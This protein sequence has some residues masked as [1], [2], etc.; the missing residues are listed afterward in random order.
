VLP[1]RAAGADFLPVNFEAHCRACHP[2]R[3]PAGVRAPDVVAGFDVAHR[4]RPAQLKAELQVGY[5]RGLL[6]AD[7]PTLAAPARPG[8]AFD[9]RHAVAGRTLRAATDRLVRDAEAV[10]LSASTGCAKCHDV[11]K[12]EV[13]PL[14]DHP[15]WLTMAR[16]NHARHKPLDCKACHPGTGAAFVEPGKALVEKEPLQILGIDSCRAC[17]SP[18][19][20]RVKLPDGAVLAGG[21]ARHG[22]VD[23]HK[24]HNAARGLQGRGAKALWPHRPLDIAEFLRGGG[25]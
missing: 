17:H 24:Y 14:P 16:F 22:C 2:L 13:K 6:A 5:L 10:L 1:A 21:G 4:V 9:P 3:A 7:H 18:S 20:T 19:G 23:C 11:E 12:G 25:K 8:G 15:V